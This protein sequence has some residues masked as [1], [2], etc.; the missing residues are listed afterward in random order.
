MKQ[1]LLE[2]KIKFWTDS[3]VSVKNIMF[4][5]L[6]ITKIFFNMIIRLMKKLY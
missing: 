1:T 4:Y 3:Y 6:I 5:I 2:M